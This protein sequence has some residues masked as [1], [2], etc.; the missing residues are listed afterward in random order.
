MKE[1]AFV[2]FSLLVALLGVAALDTV[3]HG[4]VADSAFRPSVSTPAHPIG[5]GP[6]LAIDA[7]HLNH[8]TAEGGYAPLAELLRLDGYRVSTS[9]GPFSATTLTR[10][11]VL[12]VANAMHEQ[13][14]DD[15][16]PLPTLAAFTPDEV[17]A[18]ERWVRDGGALLLIADHMP[19]AGHA[20]DLAAAFGV[21]F[22]NGFALDAAQRGDIVFRRSDGSLADHAITRGRTLLLREAAFSFT[23]KTPRIAAA[24]LLQGAA[25]THGRGRVVVLGEAAVFGAQFRGAAKTPIGM[26][27]PEGRDNAQ[28]ARNIVR[29]LSEGGH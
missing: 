6:R 3:P 2:C 28:F 8:H 20:A 13:S 19:L 16:A 22:L 4:Q 23:P 15:W 27:A 24:H 5:T 14:K 7:A 25:V 29:W 11:D 10:I 26:N 1:P 21:R 17:R 12:I 9:R 18:V